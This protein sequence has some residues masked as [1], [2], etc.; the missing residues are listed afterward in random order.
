[1]L[2][3]S[4]PDVNKLTELVRRYKM[5]FNLACRKINQLE[6]KPVTHYGNREKLMKQV[7]V[8]I[9]CKHNSSNER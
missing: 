8:I 4:M 9:Q 5:A 3:K 1:M 7:K 6:G 2:D